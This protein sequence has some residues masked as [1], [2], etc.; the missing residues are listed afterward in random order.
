MSAVEVMLRQA[1]QPAPRR[2][3]VQALVEEKTECQ[4]LQPARQRH[5]VQALRLTRDGVSI[6]ELGLPGR[7]VEH[8]CV[9]LDV[10]RTRALHPM[11]RCVC[12]SIWMAL[13]LCSWNSLNAFN[14]YG[15]S[16]TARNNS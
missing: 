11:S 8:C 6:A 2:H 5:V 7:G 4:A 1:L 12:D 13:Q 14:V 9:I 16:V 3:V 10:C 15:A